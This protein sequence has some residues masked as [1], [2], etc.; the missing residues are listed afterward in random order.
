MTTRKE[1]RSQL[2]GSVEQTS[3][4]RRPGGRT[5]STP[6]AGQPA[7]TSKRGEQLQLLQR[8]RSTA[9]AA[10]ENYAARGALSQSQVRAWQ[11][12]NTLIEKSDQ[13]AE[14]IRGGKLRPE[15]RGKTSPKPPAEAYADFD[16]SGR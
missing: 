4:L 6:P 8:L 10:T 3:G 16:W 9:V 2:A 15:D 5:N 12:L 14:T 7:A 13:L 11:K 1:H